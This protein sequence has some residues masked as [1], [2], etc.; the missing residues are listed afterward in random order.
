MYGRWKLVSCMHVYLLV[1]LLG[2]VPFLFV[3]RYLSSFGLIYGSGLGLCTPSGLCCSGKEGESI[4]ASR[5]I[6]RRGR[7]AR[8]TLRRRK[9]RPVWDNIWE[10]VTTIR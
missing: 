8:Q 3:A 4:S 6:L 1:Y 10:L 7:V 2:R 9:N 5:P